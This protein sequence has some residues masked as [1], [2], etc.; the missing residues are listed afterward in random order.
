MS[1]LERAQCVTIVRGHEHDR[2]QV[3][4]LQ[5]LDHVEAVQLGHLNV[6]KN[7]VGLRC[8]DRLDCA[9]AV[10]ALADDRDVG[11]P[12]EQP[13]NPSACNRFVVDQERAD[14]HTAA[15]PER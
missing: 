7:E 12:G 13:A 3:A 5:C 10:G 11:L 2:R 4:R 6:E 14:R 9:R 15:A 8:G 1:A